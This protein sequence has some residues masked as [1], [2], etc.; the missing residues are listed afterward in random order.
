MSE[1]WNNSPYFGLSSDRWCDVPDDPQDTSERPNKRPKTGRDSTNTLPID[2]A[3]EELEQIMYHRDVPIY[4]DNGGMFC[5]LAYNDSD[6]RHRKVKIIKTHHLSSMRR[7]IGGALQN[8]EGR[9][10]YMNR[11][12]RLAI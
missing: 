7:I 4:K 3:E 6:G 8:N 11:T 12:Y 10:R 9:F 5:L 2:M 1:S